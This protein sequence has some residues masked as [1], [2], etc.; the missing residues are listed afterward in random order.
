MHPKDRDGLV[1]YS[2]VVVCQCVKQARDEQRKVNL[3]KYCELPRK[4]K[5]MT[6]ESFRLTENLREAFDACRAIAEGTSEDLWVTLMSD[7]GRGKT[8]LAVAVVNYWLARNKPAKYV[9]VPL[10]MKELKDGFG[11]TGSDSYKSRYETFLN[12]PLLVMD[13]LG[14]ENRTPWVQEHL[15]TLFDYRLMHELPMVITTNC[16]FDELPFRIASRLRRGGEIIVI[17]APEYD[18]R[19]RG[20]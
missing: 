20:R 6:F 17:D 9:Y 5:A 3:L 15:D 16:K 7:T 2:R 18:A 4:G 11:Q 19:N 14:T 12:A 13:D 1:D 8:H 10:L